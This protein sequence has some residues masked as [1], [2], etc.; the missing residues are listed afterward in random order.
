MKVVPSVL[1]LRKGKSRKIGP[2][3]KWLAAVG[4]GLTCLGLAIF[5]SGYFS[6]QLLGVDCSGFPM[7]LGAF[8]AIVG[9]FL[10]NRILPRH[11][12]PIQAEDFIV[13]S[14]SK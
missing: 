10:I 4:V 13:R 8:A 2:K 1:R 3:D 5:F 6:I 9:L 12:I 14:K 11:E 7:S